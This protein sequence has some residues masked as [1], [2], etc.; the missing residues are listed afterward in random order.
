MKTITDT[1]VL[2]LSVKNNQYLPNG[3]SRPVATYYYIVD[4]N[5]YTF[6][7]TDKKWRKKELKDMKHWKYNTE[8]S[9]GLTVQ[10]LTNRFAS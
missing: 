1:P 7:I 5:G 10:N 2:P 8:S 4:A 9:A 6:H 3:F